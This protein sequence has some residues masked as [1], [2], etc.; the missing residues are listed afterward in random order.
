MDWSSFRD[1][2]EKKK[3]FTREVGILNWN[4]FIIQRMRNAKNGQ[5]KWIKLIK[6]D[7]SQIYCDSVAM[8]LYLPLGNLFIQTLINSIQIREKEAQQ[9]F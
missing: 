9:K 6:S 8:A 7:G 4:C 3:P 2:I 1:G 5:L